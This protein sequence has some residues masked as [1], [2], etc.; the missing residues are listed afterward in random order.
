MIP[1]AAWIGVLL[2][3]LGVVLFVSRLVRYHPEFKVPVVL[4]IVGLILVAWSTILTAGILAFIILLAGLGL[5]LAGIVI[6]IGRLFK[7]HLS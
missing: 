4:M 3:I 2:T 7:Y 5:G 1:T 6:F